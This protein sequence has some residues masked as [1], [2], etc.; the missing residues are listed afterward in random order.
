MLTDASRSWTAIR[1]LRR[2]R[3]S[4]RTPA[5]MA[6]KKIGRVPAAWII[7]TAAGDGE[8][9]QCLSVSTG[10]LCGLN[11]GPLITERNCNISLDRIAKSETMI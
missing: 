8:R 3:M 10:L 4:V 2:S 6:S 1:N 5:G 11:A 7:A 9:C